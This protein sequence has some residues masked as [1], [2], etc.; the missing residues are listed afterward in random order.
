MPTPERDVSL[1]YLRTFLTLLVV[2]HHAVLAYY[3]Y[4]P[5][6]PASLL[7]NQ[8]WGAFPVVD[9]VRWPGIE[10]LVSFNDT[11]FMSLMFLI[12]GV[13]AWSSLERKGGA[14]FTMDRVRKLGAAFVFSALVLAPIA[15]YPA[16]LSLAPQ[17]TS[18]AEQWLSL[19]S[20]PAGPAWFLWVLVVFAALAALVH[21]RMRGFYAAMGRLGA[22]PAVF[23][24]VLVGLSAL[25]YLPMAAAVSPFHWWSFGPFFVQ[26]SRILLYALYF[27]VGIALGSQGVASGLFATDGR[28]ARRWPAWGVGSVVAF[29]ANVAVF[30]IAVV[31]TLAKGG[32]GPVI[33]AASSFAFVVCCATASLAGIAFFA[34]V[35]R[36]PNRVMDSL[37]ANALGIYLAHYMCVTWLQFA[38]L[39]VPTTGSV[40]GILVF[41]GAVLVSWGL[42]AAVRR[43]FFGRKAA[44]VMTTATA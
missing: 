44:A 10:I 5:P 39:P 42:S 1:G 34:R 28:L 11:F 4:A 33:L 15:Y 24:L 27:F 35:V 18:F 14:H 20:W 31:P 8:A 25:A 43:V 41:A 21:S 23:F 22:R 19:G 36:R 29:V 9:S 30:L 32:P 17:A 16:Y 2:A 12:S 37:S 40:K 3:P 7:E 26:T 13:F 38:L 6:R